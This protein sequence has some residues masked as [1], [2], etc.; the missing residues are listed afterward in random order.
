[1]ASTTFWARLVWATRELR[2]DEEPFM[3]MQDFNPPSV[4]RVVEYSQNI[5]QLTG[6]AKRIGESYLDK[7]WSFNVRISGANEEEVNGYINKL[8]TFIELARNSNSKLYFE[9]YPHNAFGYIP[10]YGQGVYRYYIKDGYCNVSSPWMTRDVHTVVTVNLTIA[11]QAEGSR[12]R[13]ANAKGMVLSGERINGIDSVAIGYAGTNLVTNPVFSNTT[14]WD[15]GWLAGGS[16]TVTKN[17]DPD[18]ILFG[19]ASAKISVTDDAGDG[20][21]LSPVDVGTAGTT[22]KY[23]VSCYVKKP[24]NTAFG[25][26]DFNL[27]FDTAG[28]GSFSSISIGNG[29]YRIYDYSGTPSGTQVSTGIQ[30]VSPGVTFYMQGFQVEQTD[31]GLT[32]L[33]QPD[34][35]R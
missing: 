19:D 29:W 25:T 16:I 1:M 3:L 5:H 17:T 21:Y 2:L 4:G 15:T 13:L 35:I 28:L 18:Y 10:L 32:E 26:S 14:A 12:Q 33:S 24:D 11:P 27:Y 34:N 9:Y 8:S 22:N 6:G 20:K 7:E 31:A 23:C 30:V